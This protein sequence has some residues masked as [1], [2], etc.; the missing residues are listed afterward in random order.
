MDFGLC[1]FLLRIFATFILTIYAFTNLNILENRLFIMYSELDTKIKCLFFVP[2]KKY[3]KTLKSHI[4]SPSCMKLHVQFYV[5]T[6]SI[7]DWM[8]CVGRKYSWV[9]VCWQISTNNINTQFSCN[10]ATVF[11]IYLNL[12]VMYECNGFRK[13][14]K[15]HNI[16]VFSISYSISNHNM[17]TLH[18]YYSFLQ[19]DILPDW[20]YINGNTF[21]DIRD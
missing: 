3:A 8:E 14:S 12:N 6:F 16:I 20:V 5:L 21:V 11:E 18:S 15:K 2:H 9:Y 19:I 4:A 10:K 1:T 13:S 7:I 17:S